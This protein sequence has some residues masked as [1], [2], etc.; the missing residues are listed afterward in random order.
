MA[1]SL[2][3]CRISSPQIL[4][5]SQFLK[6]CIKNE[7]S[8]KPWRKIS[9]VIAK[10][11]ET[12]KTSIEDTSLLKRGNLF[13][14]SFNFTGNIQLSIWEI[15]SFTI[16]YVDLIP[17]SYALGSWLMNWSIR[18]LLESISCSIW[19][20]FA[21]TEDPFHQLLWNFLLCHYLR[22]NVNP[23]PNFKSSPFLHFL[24]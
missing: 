7:S 8:S 2:Y 14:W 16:A 6:P 21:V 1:T 4:F 11:W 3:K 10:G 20:Y 22:S 15:P 19:G 13:G 23:N 12:K 17:F 5:P 24:I 18:P 9:T